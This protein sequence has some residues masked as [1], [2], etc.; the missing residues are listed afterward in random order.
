M[1]KML[2]I[3][4]HPWVQVLFDLYFSFPKVTTDKEPSLDLN[5][6]LS[7]WCALTWGNVSLKH[8]QKSRVFLTEFNKQ[9]HRVE[10]EMHNVGTRCLAISSLLVGRESLVLQ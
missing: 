3:T 7:P 6:G 10:S 1:Q 8:L 2:I 5:P 9:L 4:G